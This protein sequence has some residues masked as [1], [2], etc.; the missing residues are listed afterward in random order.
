MVVPLPPEATRAILALHDR[1]NEFPSVALPPLTDIHVTL[2]MPFFWKASEEDLEERLEQAMAGTHVIELKTDGLAIF[3]EF[4]NTLHLRLEASPPLQTLHRRVV[5]ALE[6]VK[7]RFRY[8]PRIEGPFYVPHITV[9]HRLSPET[10]AALPRALLS[11]P[12]TL[13]VPV[14]EA[15]LLHRESEADW[16]L[17]RAYRFLTRGGGSDQ[18]LR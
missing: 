13:S 3:D 1:L 5:S 9:G 6:G 17:D 7:N 15:H 8:T 18:P 10:V 14:S 11:Q 16:R 2:K 12:T 4:Y